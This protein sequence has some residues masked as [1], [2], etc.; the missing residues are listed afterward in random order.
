M[1]FLLCSIQ[2]LIKEWEEENA[3]N[4]HKIKAEWDIL[5]DEKIF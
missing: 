5:M 2:Q 4:P 3:K 1:S